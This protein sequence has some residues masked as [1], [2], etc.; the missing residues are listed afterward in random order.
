MDIA[1]Y[2]GHPNAGIVLY[3]NV[4]SPDA[5]FVE[6]IE[7]ALRAHENDAYK[8]LPATVG[9]YEVMKNY[10]DCYDLKIGERSLHTLPEEMSDLKNVYAEVIAG[11]RECVRHYSSLYNLVLE[12]EEVTNFVKYEEGQFFGVHPDSGFAYFCTVSSIGYINDDYEGGEYLMPFQDVM[13]KPE[14]GDLIIHPSNFIYA[15]SSRPVTKGVK[16]SAVTMYDYNDRNHQQQ[17]QPGYDPTTYPKP[18]LPTVGG[19]QVS[20]AS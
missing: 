4:W 13:F 3:K 2:I 7:D 18:D 16:Y 14:K 10:R 15:H 8:W 17:N 5:N 9:D 19:G 12:Y 20:S 6:R 1:G 11:V